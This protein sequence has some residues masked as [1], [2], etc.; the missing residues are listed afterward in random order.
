MADDSI[1]A[2]YVYAE[3][4]LRRV[5]G[6]SVETYNV[7]LKLGFLYASVETTRSHESSSVVWYRHRFEV[8]NTTLMERGADGKQNTKV[9]IFLLKQKYVLQ[10][11]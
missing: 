6:D 1:V 5:S 10:C 4:S 8:G 7:V 11:L 2:V 9:H 3:V